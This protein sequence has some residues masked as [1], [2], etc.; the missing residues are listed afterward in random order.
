MFLV[1]N[2]H[3]NSGHFYATNYHAVNIMLSLYTLDISFCFNA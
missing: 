1:N 3:Y 2:W